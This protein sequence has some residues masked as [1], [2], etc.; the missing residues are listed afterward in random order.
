MN[1]FE[2]AKYL[3]EN[4][5]DNKIESYLKTL[6]AKAVEKFSDKLA[7]GYKVGIKF[8][9]SDSYD[10]IKAV[11]DLFDPFDKQDVKEYRVT[12]IKSAREARSKIRA[13]ETTPPEPK[14]ADYESMNDYQEALK[15]WR[16]QKAAVSEMI[17]RRTN[18]TKKD[19]SDDGRNYDKFGYPKENKR[20][21]NTLLKIKNYIND[22]AK[23]DITNSFK[24]KSDENIKKVSDEIIDSAEKILA[25]VKI[26]SFNDFKKHPESKENIYKGLFT[27]YEIAKKKPLEFKELTDLKRAI[28]SI[29][30]KGTHTDTSMAATDSANEEL[31]GYKKGRD[32]TSSGQIASLANSAIGDR[33]TVSEL[34]MNIPTD[35][36]KLQIKVQEIFADMGLTKFGGAAGHKLIDPEA[37]FFLGGDKKPTD[38][39]ET[40]SDTT[41][42]YPKSQ[43]EKS[44]YMK[45]MLILKKMYNWHPRGRNFKDIPNEEIKKE[46]LNIKDNG[47]VT[48]LALKHRATSPSTNSNVV[49]KVSTELNNIKSD[50]KSAQKRRVVVPVKRPEAA[51]GVEKKESAYELLKRTRGY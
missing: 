22:A 20:S 41:K 11:F 37:R 7:Q 12:N 1:S 43:E 33:K 28:L 17:R 44:D 34:D 39:P 48:L 15:L 27:A 8:T 26:F 23:A 36:A 16:T 30:R 2:K 40:T 21:T 45:G 3:L 9:N 35:V 4:E 6:N 31:Y 47:I 42:L 10:D 14:K 19:G 46:V 49:D 29:K 25:A 51:T 24:S 5:I 13:K 18:S 50:I 38:D 32:D